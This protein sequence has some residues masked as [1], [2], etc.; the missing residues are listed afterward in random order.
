M[1]AASE[2]NLYYDTSVPFPAQL[3]IGRGALTKAHPPLA[4]VWKLTLRSL[5]AHPVPTSDDS[6]LHDT[7]AIV[8]TSPDHPKK[9]DPVWGP[10]P[11]TA[12]VPRHGMSFA[13]P[14]SGSCPPSSSR[15]LVPACHPAPTRHPT[16]ARHPARHQTPTRDRCACASPSLPA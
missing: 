7:L 15:H 13:T 4:L 1:P 16:L 3:R 14:S 10:H 8:P 6:V 11:A 2:A 5:C 9:L 12:V